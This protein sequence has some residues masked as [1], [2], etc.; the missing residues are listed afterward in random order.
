MHVVETGGLSAACWIEAFVALVVSVLAIKK[1]LR[2]PAR[3]ARLARRLGRFEAL[4]PRTHKEQRGF[5]LFSV[6]AGITEEFVYRAFLITV[7]ANWTHT[8]NVTTA[9][10][11]SSALF[12]IA[13]VYQGR[14][15]V[16][17]TGVLGLGLAVF[18]VEGG[19]LLAMLVHALIDLRLLLMSNEFLDEVA[20]RQPEAPEASAEARLLRNPQ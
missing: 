19:L 10:A 18:A 16:F 14:R 3:R 5:V 9:V 8:T 7:L 2:A 17:L 11:A 12:G 4:L 13:H 15:N 1:L 6:T 20:P